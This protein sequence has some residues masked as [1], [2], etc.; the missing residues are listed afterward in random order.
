MFAFMEQT[1]FNMDTLVQ[2]N[3]VTVMQYAA[4]DL[5]ENVVTLAIEK[6]QGHMYHGEPIS[7]DLWGM[8]YILINLKEISPTL[9][10]NQTFRRLLS[11]EN[12][13]FGYSFTSPKNGKE[14]DRHGVMFPTIDR[15][16]DLVSV[17]INTKA[18]PFL[19]YLGEDENE[20]GKTYFSK[21]ATLALNGSHAKRIYKLLCSWKSSGGLKKSIE[22]IKTMLDIQGKYPKLAEFK[23]RV[24]EPARKEMLENKKSDIWFE[25]KPYKSKGSKVND[26]ISF[27]IFTRY[28][29]KA[30]PVMDADFE[31]W[32]EVYA[33]LQYCLGIVNQRAQEIADV[34]KE[35]GSK[36]L[37]DRYNDSKRL[38][39][40]TPVKAF[41]YFMSAA[42]KAC[43]ENKVFKMRYKDAKSIE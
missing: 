22:D 20:G 18:I 11:I 7:R 33:F 27:K 37:K 23:R 28:E 6:L 30:S 34:S 43:P 14:V 40:E 38:R 15:Q 3:R 25:Y 29:K 1:G 17:E 2:P 41:N 13:K 10:P 24:L 31:H 39:D 8:P 26:M 12:R 32:R 36:F 21:K 19:L 16:G 4:K 5:E 42:E 35:I 9:K